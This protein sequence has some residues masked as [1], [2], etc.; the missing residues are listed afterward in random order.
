MTASKSLDGIGNGRYVYCLVQTGDEPTETLPV[1]GIDDE[2]PRV[3]ATE[4]IGAIVHETDSL[5]DSDDPATIRHWLLAHHRVVEAATERFGTPVPFQFDV[6]LEGTDETVRSVLE[7]SASEIDAAFTDVTGRREYRIELLFE[8]DATIPD[9]EG[10]LAALREEVETAGD[11]T[12]FLLETKLERKQQERKRERASALAADLRAAIS[13]VT[14]S[15]TR[16]N[17]DQLGLGGEDDRET[18]TELAVL[19]DHDREDELGSRL[20]PIADEPGVAIRFTGP[21]APYSFVPD[22]EL[23]GRE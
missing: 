4:G 21:W 23:E 6:V 9:P 8:P 17:S 20:D 19:A 22:I 16:A 7:S 15:V 13:D 2:S 10:E 18:V 12:A 5:Y 11:G 14:A 3:I 1:D